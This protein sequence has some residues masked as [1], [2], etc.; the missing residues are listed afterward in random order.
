MYE[1]KKLTKIYHMD[2]V[3]VIA[4]NAVSFVVPDAACGS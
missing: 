2:K 1:I 3:K 4:L